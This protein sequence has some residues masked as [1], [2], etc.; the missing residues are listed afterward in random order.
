[1]AVDSEIA[2]I[3]NRIFDR[4]DTFEEK[5]DDICTRLVRLEESVK[6]HYNDIKEEEDRKAANEN[7][8]ERKYYVLIAAMGIAFGLFEIAQ[9][10]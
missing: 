2:L 1:M 10:M 8:K 3:M 6:D 9:N 5:I 7:K 4:L